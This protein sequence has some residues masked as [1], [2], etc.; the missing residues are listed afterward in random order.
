MTIDALT[1]SR[2][3][4]SMSVFVNLTAF[5]R[6]TIHNLIKELSPKISWKQTYSEEDVGKKFLENFCYFELIGPGG[7]FFSNEMSV[8]L[9][10]FDKN[11][12]YTWHN[13]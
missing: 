6:I 12:F 4:S 7:Y 1:V 10:Y 5:S 11:T 9:I 13:H 3:L 2:S 8:Y